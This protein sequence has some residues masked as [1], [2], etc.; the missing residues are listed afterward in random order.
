MALRPGGMFVLE[1]YTPRQLEFRTGG[2][3]DTDLLMDVEMLKADLAGLEFLVAHEVQRDIQ[4]GR[5]HGGRSAVV[6]I[7]ARSPASATLAS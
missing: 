1:A 2:P 3:T 7:L 6:Q 5:L 4:E